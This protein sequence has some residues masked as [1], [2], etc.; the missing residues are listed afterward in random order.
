VV[1]NLQHYAAVGGVTGALSHHADAIYE[2]L[3]ATTERRHA[4]RLATRRLFQSLVEVGSRGRVTRRPLQFAQIVVETGVPDDDL[5]EVIEAFREVGHSFLMPPRPQPIE[6]STVIDVSHE[7]LIRQWDKLNGRD[8]DEDWLK[9]EQ[10]DA[11]ISRRLYLNLQA[12]S[13]N[14][15]RLVDGSE[16]EEFNDLVEKRKLSPAWFQRYIPEHQEMSAPG[17]HDLRA[18]DLVKA[19][20]T[21]LTESRKRQQLIIDS[22]KQLSSGVHEGDRRE[23]IVFALLSDMAGV[24]QESRSLIPSDLVEEIARARAA[25][26]TGWLRLLASEVAGLRFQWPALRVVAQAQWDLKDYKGARQTWERIR[27]NDPDDLSANLALANLFE[28]QFRQER[29]PELLENSNLAIARVLMVHKLSAEQRAEAYALHG[30]NL[31]TLWRLDF[32]AQTELAKRR[33]T[34]TNRTL[35]VAYEAY[36]KAYL[37]DLNQYYSG[38]AALQQ[39]TIA[40]ALSDEV[41]VW[42]DAFATSYEAA[43]YRAKLKQQLEALRG[44]VWQS[45][46][47]AMTR[48]EESADRLWNAISAADL[49][50]LTEERNERV[51]KAYKSAIPRNGEFAWDAAKGQLRLFALLGIKADL[52]NE[53]IV[54]MDALVDRSR[55]NK[56][57]LLHT[58][59]FA[60]HRVDEVGREKPRFPPYRETK[61]SDLIREKLKAVVDASTRVHVLSSAAPGSDILCH[62]ICCDLG[63]DST[64]CLPMPKEIFSRLMFRGQENWRVRFLELVASRPV[65]Q[66]SD[67]EGLP[68]WLRNSGLNVWERGNRWVLEMAEASGA[69]KVTLIALWDGMTTGDAPGGTAH[70]VG[71][72]R[73]AGT[74]VEVI[75]AKL[76]T[77]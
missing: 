64:I 27:D 44:S 68:R 34:A 3:G 7:A 23:D 73:D 74:V 4:L 57:V 36:R 28:R 32:G 41:D 39:G 49:S 11:E 60:G 24:S 71:L 76:L 46:E 2:R 66:L 29:R 30:R 19:I 31:K 12:F 14:P 48:T 33:E 70:M 18:G 65:L 9:E 10:A 53:V 69:T 20:E 50:F 54:A 26:S 21:L 63:I 1:L 8:V 16:I 25:E 40:L 15:R 43:A 42:E 6:D 62:E 55:P 67:Q 72:A 35:L 61:A 5:K 47:A 59:I 37:E 13:N 77:A 51:V 75:D 45:I 22:I 17:F 52:A 56:T 58:I 38:L